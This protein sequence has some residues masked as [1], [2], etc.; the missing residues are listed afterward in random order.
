MNEIEGYYVDVI[1]RHRRGFLA[2]QLRKVLI[3][4]GRLYS[5]SIF[6]RIRSKRSARIRHD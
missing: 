4:S 3:V 5:L 2:S 1:F 6:R